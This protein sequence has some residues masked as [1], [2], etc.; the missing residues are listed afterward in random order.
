M[1]SSLNRRSFLTSAAIGAAAAPMLLVP[2]SSAAAPL[3][4]GKPRFKLGLAAYSFRS[5]FKNSNRSQGGNVP[6]DKRISMQD[7]VN[8]CADQGIEGAE[9]TSYFFDST[10]RDYLLELKRI[11]FVRGISLS[12]TAIGNNFCLPKGARRDQQIASAKEWIDRAAIMGA[13]HI[14]IF[15]GPQGDLP[16]KEARSLCVEAIKECCDYAAE[17]GVFLGLENHGGIVAESEVLLGIVDEVDHPWLGI[18]LDSGNFHTADPYRDLELCAP[19]A[20]NVQI[21][22]ELRPKDRPAESTDMNRIASILKKSGYQGYVV[23]EH[24]ANEDPWEFVPRHMKTMRA[25]LLG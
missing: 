21:K 16:F 12:G 10:D 3:R 13:P 15:A 20:V 6:E 2:G 11:A 24:E 22:T 18:N 7:F 5:Y 19:Y 9:V 8:Y 23:L 14:R 17:R 1:N 4:S 25:A